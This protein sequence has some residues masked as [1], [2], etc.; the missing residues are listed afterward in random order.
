MEPH[1]T[2][3]CGIKHVYLTLMALYIL[4][5]QYDE[6]KDQWQGMFNKA[7]T[8]FNKIGL[9]N[10]DRIIRL[11]TVKTKFPASPPLPQKK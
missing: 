11:F 3:E 8:F 10:T 4:K 7:K 9:K 6:D 1:L 2:N 5:E